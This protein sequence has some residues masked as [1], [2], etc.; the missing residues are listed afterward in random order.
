MTVQYKSMQHL[1][2]FSSEN[3]GL[4]TWNRIGSLHRELAIY[5]KLTENAWKVSFFTYDKSPKPPNIGFNASIHPQWPFWMPKKLNPVYC[6]FLPLRFLKMGTTI[7]VIITNQAHSPGPAVQ[8]AKLWNAKLIARCGY[9]YGESATVLGKSGKRV[10]KRIAVER[11][12]FENADMCVV[13]T[14]KL[15]DWIAENYSIDAGKVAVIPNYVDTNIFRPV[16]KTEMPCDIIC[17]GRLVGKKRH[18]LLIMALEGTALRLLIIGNGKLKGRLQQLAAQLNVNLKILP[19]VEHR[20]LPEYLNNA[21]IYANL[22][23]WEG[24]PKGLIEAMACGCACI[25][26]KSPGI[27]NLITDGETGKLVAPELGQ[28]RNTVETLL[29]DKKTAQQLGKAAR[30]CAV[31]E[32]S[33]GKV[34]EQY[35]KVFKEALHK[36]KQV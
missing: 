21:T 30:S 29:K 35:E 20:Q 25:G 15:K 31:A 23:R 3:S 11:H 12:T 17:I 10:Q 5:K 9:V 32:F 34:A 28:I 8:A 2:I 36:Y 33:L 19:R 22:S 4:N 27:E 14:D 18:E 1:A 7:D 13:P 26:A 24:H 6:K 16:K